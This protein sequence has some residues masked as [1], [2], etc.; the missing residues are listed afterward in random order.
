LWRNAA[1]AAVVAS[2][3]V[4][5]AALPLIVTDEGMLHVGVSTGFVMLVVTAHDK[6]TCPVNP[7]DGVT[8]TT[9]VLPLVAPGLTVIAPLL[10]NVKP[11]TAEEPVTVTVKLVDAV[12][13]PVV[14]SVPVTVNV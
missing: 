11:A 8:V 2:V 3:S 6:L 5:V 1:L 9:A 12:I 10:L 7:F 13:F 4:A 14:A